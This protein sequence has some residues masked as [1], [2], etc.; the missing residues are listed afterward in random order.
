VP[1]EFNFEISPLAYF[2]RTEFA[3]TVSPTSGVVEPSQDVTIEFSF[4]TRNAA[5][6]MGHFWLDIQPAGSNSPTQIERYLMLYEAHPLQFG[7]HLKE[8]G[9]DEVQ[10]L[11]ASARPLATGGEG[12]IYLGET[13]ELGQVVIKQYIT[14]TD[15]NNPE[16]W[17]FLEDSQE[18][19]RRE[20]TC[21]DDLASLSSANSNIVKAYGFCRYPPC[22]LMEYVGGGSVA[23]LIER[24][25]TITSK[26][27]YTIA[28]GILRALSFLH[29]NGIIH[30]YVYERCVT[31]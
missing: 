16:E 4:E 6:R 25:E 19:F 21:F 12:A 7:S 22:V 20:V 5:K 2:P 17:Q 28:R 29:D 31:I 24:G 8:F 3:F 30:R 9:S 11:L 13:P 27:L 23:S 1:L 26:Q 18:A 14:F 10:T 15:T